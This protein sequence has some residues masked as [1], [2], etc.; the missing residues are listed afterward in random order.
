M[1][2]PP[3][4]AGWNSGGF[5]LPVLIYRAMV[6]HITALGF[7]WAGANPYQ[8]YRKRFDEDW[9]IDLM[10]ILNSYGASARLKLDE[11][12]AVI[13]VPGKIGVDGS[14]VLPLYQAGQLEPIRTYCGK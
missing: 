8:G 1:K 14:Q 12:A 5:G 6:H 4:L 9:H 11:M 2:V 13:G 3:Q 7:Y 10:D